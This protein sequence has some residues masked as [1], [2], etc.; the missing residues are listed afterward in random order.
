MSCS[1]VLLAAAAD[2]NGRA[3]SESTC[4]G[5][6][7]TGSPKHGV[8]GSPGFRRDVNLGEA[9]AEEAALAAV[10]AVIALASFLGVDEL[11]RIE[12]ACPIRLRS[13][14]KVIAL[15]RTA[16]SCIL[17]GSFHF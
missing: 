8:L 5:A 4:L 12:P 15:Q 1:L 6:A 3:P 14:R 11:P 13:F 10:G 17:L 16:S 7:H 9:D 2:A